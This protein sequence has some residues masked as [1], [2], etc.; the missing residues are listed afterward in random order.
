M[1]GVAF[2]SPVSSS[3]TNSAFL[4]ANG[5]DTALGKV[6]FGNTDPVSGATIDNIQREAN[7]ESSFTG[8]P[9]N[10]A[11]DALPS[12][13][14]NDAG[15]NTDN[16]KDRADALSAKFNNATGHAH[17]GSA[18]DGAPISAQTIL[19]TPLK[20]FGIRAIDLSGVTGT[21]TDVSTELSGKSPSSGT[22]DPG[23]VVTA[24]YNTAILR[25]GSGA[26]VGDEFVDGFGNVVYG[27]LTEASGTWT[28]SYFVNLAGTETAYSFLTPVDVTWYYQELYNPLDN[29]P[30]YDTSFFIP[31]DNATQDVVDASVS[32]RG[33][34]NTSTQSFGGNKTFV[35]D[36]TAAARVMGASS[37][38]SSTTGSNAAVPA[39][40][41]L[42]LELT[43]ASLASI[44]TVTGGG[45]TQVIIL[46][47]STGNSVR[48]LNNV[49][50]AGILTG[51]N[52]DTDFADT[53]AMTLVY[54]PVINRWYV[55]S[56]AGT[57]FESRVYPIA[58]ASNITTPTD[59]P[60]LAF[61]VA[62]FRGA[63]IDFGIK[64]TTSGKYRKGKL[65]IACDGTA[66][67]YF[68]DYVETALLGQGPT[69]IVFTVTV[70]TG[71]VRIAYENTDVTNGATM[72]AF[73]KHL[74]N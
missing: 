71:N 17:S 49:G 30:V 2:G 14:S 5:D 53:A 12:W 38:D 68:S 36:L 29:P 64:E 34:V 67:S 54:M 20:G 45:S 19:N 26:G 41:T 51:V 15:T 69:G 52:S 22:T 60:S 7:A 3:N 50:A 10:S 44:G 70:L 65:E 27:R 32:Q 58:L 24:P 9:L 4:D 33:V 46:I 55:S 48:I 35:G 13:S 25:Q 74:V 8:L 43:N 56:G 61:A 1:S 40:G 72:E 11:K 39:P 62:S 57:G 63:Q 73:V 28:L 18:G 66:V 47:N 16:L 31:S 37:T 59:I 42:V 6:G 23:V 21:S